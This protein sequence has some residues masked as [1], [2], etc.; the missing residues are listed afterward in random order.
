M[1]EPTEQ[2]P[3]SIKINDIR[4]LNLS[5]SDASSEIRTSFNEDLLNFSFQIKFSWDLEKDLFNVFL[6]GIYTYKHNGESVEMLSCVC[7][8]SYKIKNLD[9]FLTVLPNNKE[10]NMSPTIMTLVVGSA[11][12]HAR[13]AISEKTQGTFIHDYYLPLIKLQDFMQTMVSRS[14]S[15]EPEKKPK[16][17]FKAPPIKRRKN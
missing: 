9:R 17:I 4:V 1:T 16:K 12:S 8:T 5:Y 6:D 11:L 14:E 7:V 15:T 10:F 3:L 13:G 2:N